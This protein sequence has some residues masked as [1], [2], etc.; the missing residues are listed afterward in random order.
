[1]AVRFNPFTGTLDLVGI[2]AVPSSGITSINGLIAAAQ[3]LAVGSSGSD[4]NINSASSTH[5]IN[6]PTASST[7]TGKLSSIDFQTF[8][9]KADYDDVF[10]NYTT[11]LNATNITNKYVV[12]PEAPSDKPST[13]LD[14]KT[15]PSQYYGDD[16]V[17]TNDDGGKRLSWD[18]L[19]LDG[20][21]ID[22]DK[23]RVLYK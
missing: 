7:V 13:I 3:A 5:T 19:A 11:I 14:L 6:I 4:V 17:V 9:S 18:S 22:G 16:F 1:M 15:A 10:K 2:T 20:I 8:Q 21:L 12:L 23:I